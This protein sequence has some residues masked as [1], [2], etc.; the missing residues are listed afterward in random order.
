MFKNSKGQVRTGWLIFVTLIITFVIQAIF[1]LP[2]EMYALFT[3]ASDGDGTAVFTMDRSVI[4]DGRPWLDVFSYALGYVAA[5]ISLL[6]L[7]K[8]LNKKKIQD[9]GFG[10]FLINIIFGLLLGAIS[11]AIIFF[12]LLFTDNIELINT[13]SNPNFS[14]Y[15]ITYLI[16]FILVG[17]FEELVFRGYIMSTLADR[18]RRKVT[19]YMVSA[20]IFGIAHLANQNVT[21][22]GIFNI[23]LVGILFAYMY[24][25]TQSLWTPIGYH[26]TWNY[27]QG[28]VFG[29]PVSGTT[30]YGVYTIDVSSGNDLLTGGS[31]GLEGGLLATLMIIFGFICTYLFSGKRKQTSIRL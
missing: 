23:F 8:F 10:L 15:S 4:M 16:F 2:V 22:L 21:L 5:L 17:L 1:M 25:K 27:F 19:I 31:F 12:I 13:L 20:L 26:I 18:G 9:L 3:V 24:D 30:P 29:F 11:I 7:W 6:L 28:N 14:T